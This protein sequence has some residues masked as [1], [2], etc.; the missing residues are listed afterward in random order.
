M[1][2]TYAKKYLRKAFK[3]KSNKLNDK[4]IDRRCEILYQALGEKFYISSFSKIL[5][6]P[7]EKPSGLLSM[8]RYYAKNNGCYIEFK[9]QD[10]NDSCS[11][12]KYTF[13]MDE[14]FYGQDESDSLIKYAKKVVNICEP[15]W[16]GEKIADFKKLL[17]NFLPLLFLAKH[18]AFQD[19]REIRIAISFI[20][21]IYDSIKNY[22]P[23]I[24]L[25]LNT[26]SIKKIVVGPSD[27]QIDLIIKIRSYISGLKEY[28][29]VIIEKSD[30]PIIKYHK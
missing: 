12:Y 14:V 1:E 25:P 8:W 13:V 30:I 26:G 22:K 21:N 3:E 27:N 9:T 24:E 16:E 11:I 4:D 5:S 28:D 15:L 6:K 20:E 17:E 19:E 10:L 2:M 7:D 18:L 29:E 23:Y